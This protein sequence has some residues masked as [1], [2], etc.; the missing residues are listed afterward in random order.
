MQSSEKTYF[1]VLRHDRT[2]DKGLI[3]EY[4]EINP[5]EEQGGIFMVEN[6]VLLEMDMQR[7]VLTGSVEELAEGI[8]KAGD[9]RIYTE[10]RHN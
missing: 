1:S 4:F 10:F 8:R 9:L 5:N 7:N 6:K 2:L 3:L